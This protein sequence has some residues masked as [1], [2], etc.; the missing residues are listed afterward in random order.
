MKRKTIYI[1]ILAI[2][3]FVVLI[4][5][6]GLVYFNIVYASEKCPHGQICLSQEEFKF[7]QSS[8]QTN[9]IQKSNVVG[10]DTQVLSDPLYPPLNR[11]DKNTF[12]GVVYE[13]K[14]RNI[15]IPTNLSRDTF[16]LVGY[17]TSKS[18]GDDSID[19]GGNSWKLMAREK[20]KNESEFYL[21]PTNVT[22][23]IKIPLTPDIFIGERPRDMYTIPRKM[24]FKSPLLND[25]PYEFTEIPKTDFTDDH[26]Y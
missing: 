14:N 11:T 5:S 16:H 2:S 22:Y 3:V 15:N 10:R 12:D 4:I 23:S 26:Y 20:T 8:K 13:T 19:S 24:Q 18:T 25:T 1:T 17:L 7:I 6:S 21:I 9:N